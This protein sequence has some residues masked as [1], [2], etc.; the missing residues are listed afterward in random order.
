LSDDAALAFLLAAA[1]TWL[2][3]S[4]IAAILLIAT[5]VRQSVVP[6]DL[7]L[8]LM[9]GTNL[10]GALIAAGLTR[11]AVAD[12]KAVTLANLI[13]RGLGA[14]AAA[15]LIAR[16]VPPLERLSADPATRIILAHIAFNT[17]ILLAGAL[18]APWVAGLARRLAGRRGASGNLLDAQAA[19]AL[20]EAALSF[21]RQAIANATREVLRLT[22]DIDVMLARIIDLYRNAETDDMKSLGRLDD[23]VD[24]RHAAIKL[25]LARATASDVSEREAIACQE[26]IAACV[27]LEQVGD[28]IVRNMLTHVQKMRDRK[29]EFSPEG[30][31]ELR[32]MHAA[33]L[34]NARLAFNVLVSRDTATARR[35]VEEKDRM[36]ELER[37]AGLK[38]FERLRHG[39]PATVESSS[40]HLDTIRDLKEINALLASLAYPVLEEQGL[41][42]GSRLKKT[43]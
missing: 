9:L 16:H 30:W 3:H 41:L 37:D 17:V 24:R 31:S 23:R 43:G 25:Y 26:L 22:E 35:L 12:Q 15:I 19:S 36:R 38:H 5:L 13:V 8:D 4:S 1:L 18:V 39:T 42:S 21:P 14:A 20:D 29:L 27:K 7:G 33:V 10:G 11:G 2:M 32:A 6:V 40:I 28:I 34:A